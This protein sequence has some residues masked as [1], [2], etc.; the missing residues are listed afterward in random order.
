MVYKRHR[1]LDMIVM[2]DIETRLSKIKRI[3]VTPDLSSLGDSEYQALMHC[4]HAA[5]LISAVYRKQAWKDSTGLACD[6]SKRTDEQGQKLYD[7]M[8]IHG[9]PWDSADE[10]T[11]FVP[12]YDVSRPPGAAHYPSDITEEEWSA[13]LE[14]NPNDREAFESPNTLIVRNQDSLLA[15]PYSNAYLRDLKEADTYLR[16]AADML[17]EGPLKTYL[18]HRSRELISN[19]YWYG[20]VAWVATTGMPFE[21]NI[22]PYEVHRDLFM[23]LKAGFQA[24][25]GIK[26]E[27]T[28]KFFENLVPYALEFDRNLAQ[29]H[30]FTPRGTSIPMVVVHDVFRGGELA[31][32]RQF[33]AQNLPNDR[34]IHKMV[35]SRKVF[36]RLMLDAKPEYILQPI[37]ERLF[38]SHAVPYCTPRAFR[39]LIGAHEVAHGMGP[40]EVAGEAEHV[41]VRSRLK[42]Y[43]TIIEEGKADV[44]GIDLLIYCRYREY[45]TEEDLRD[46]VWTLFTLY[47]SDFK[48]GFKGHGGGSLV[49]YNWLRSRHGFSYD[50]DT[51]KL[52]VDVSRTIEVLRELADEFMSIQS[53]GDIDR[54]A[55]FLEGHSIVPF[56]IPEML[57]VIEDVP[58]DV[59]PTFHIT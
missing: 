50:C 7:F 55:S 47:F 3:D 49:Q 34:R 26:D 52:D 56:S 4:L 21:I 59:H 35:G 46:V 42:K 8:C 58:L 1:T 48:R 5:R 57:Q 25:I 41:E 27:E 10:F 13:H 44:L 19:N 2:T 53:A 6:I 16:A 33:T 30:G 22:G 43:H 51:G 11:S 15:V 12:G 17:G 23:G 36:S 40:T 9:D 39:L 37:A 20:D 54:A 18:E 32:G 45:I 29:S 38:P 14:D 24:F 31:F 28:T